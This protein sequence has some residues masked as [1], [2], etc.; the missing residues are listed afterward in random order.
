MN[1][2]DMP[3]GFAM[4][5]SQNKQALFYFS[6]LDTD[7]QNEICQRVTSLTTNFEWDGGDGYK[8]T[9]LKT[10]NLSGNIEMLPNGERV[11]QLVSDNLSFDF[12][13]LSGPTKLFHKTKINLD[14]QNRLKNII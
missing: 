6:T 7:E 14:F 10:D 3:Q 9:N 5:L 1:K 8:F 13:F 4:A 12:S 2:K 11:I